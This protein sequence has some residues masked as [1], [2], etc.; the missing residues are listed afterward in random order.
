MLPTRVGMIPNS[1]VNTALPCLFLRCGRIF[2]LRPLWQQELRQECLKDS[3][4]HH[5]HR[6]SHGLEFYHLLLCPYPY[7]IPVQP[8]VFLLLF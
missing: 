5:R 2:G 7:T 4:A 3:W 1:P 6:T 8:Y